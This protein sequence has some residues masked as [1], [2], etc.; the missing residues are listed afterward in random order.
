MYW[1]FSPRIQFRNKFDLYTLKEMSR[2]Y[3][4]I[5]LDRSECRYNIAKGVHDELE[6]ALAGPGPDTL[7]LRTFFD[8]RVEDEIKIF[9]EEEGVKEQP[10]VWK[11]LETDPQVRLSS[12]DLTVYAYLKEE[13]INTEESPEVKY[14]KTKCPRLMSFVKLMDFLFEDS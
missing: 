12:L 2:A 3:Q 1:I 9:E 13:L 4:D 8:T 11:S 14:L 7:P 10:P 6:N 5:A